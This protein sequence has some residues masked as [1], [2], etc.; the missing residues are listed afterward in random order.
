MKKFDN[1]QII[2]KKNTKSRTLLASKK[3]AIVLL[4]PALCVSICEKVTAF[5][6]MSLPHNKAV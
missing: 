3:A 1:L 4:W 2:K 6:V 5:F